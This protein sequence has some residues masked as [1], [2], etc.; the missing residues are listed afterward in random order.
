[1]PLPPLR[2]ILVRVRGLDDL[3]PLADDPATNLSMPGVR[4]DYVETFQGLVPRYNVR[5]L[6]GQRVFAGER[7]F[8]FRPSWAPQGDRVALSDGAHLR[9][10]KVGAANAPTVPN[11]E[12]AIWPAWSPD[13]EWIAFT[14]TSV[15]D[16]THASCVYQAPL[17][18]CAFVEYPDGSG[19]R[20]LGEGWEP[21]WSP[22]GGSL[23]LRRDDRIWRLD[24]D[25]SSSPEAIPDTEGGREPAVSPDGRFLAFARRL[26][27]G[28]NF[29]IWVV[30]LQ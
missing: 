30:G 4:V 3:G 11:T 26:P 16:S 7:S 20:E 10:W 5:Y 23:F 25:G 24:L 18:Y 14:R 19:L 12:G 27:E 13:G 9:I 21:A 22:D 28:R 17:G 6:P 8:F 15:T 2:Q 1:V 29:D